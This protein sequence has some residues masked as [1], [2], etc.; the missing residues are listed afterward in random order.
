MAGEPPNPTPPATPPGGVVS[1]SCPGCGAPVQLRAAGHTVSVACGSCATLIDATDPN[2]QVL[3]RYHARRKRE[4]LIPL[5]SRG[6]LFGTKYEVIGFLIRSD[7]S[8]RYKWREYLLF[9]PYHGFRWLV[10]AAGHWNFVTMLRDKPTEGSHESRYDGKTFKLFLRGE[11]VVHYVLGEFY[12]RIAVGDR[13][14]V[15]DFICPPQMLSFEGDKNERIWSQAEYVEPEVVRTAFQVQAPFPAKR[16]VAPNQPAKFPSLTGIFVLLLALLIVIQGVT[17]ATARDETAWERA[18]LYLR[19]DT[20]NVVVTEPFELKGRVANVAVAVHAPVENNWI[21]FEESLVNADTGRSVAFEQGVSYYSGF[22]SD[23]AWTEGKH[24]H[25]RMLNSIPPGR[26]Q[27]RITPTTA[28]DNP[29]VL[30]T[31][32]VKRDVPNWSNFFTALGLLLI[33]PL[34][35]WFQRY[36]FEVARWSESDYSPYTHGGDDEE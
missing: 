22:D 25:V 19:G 36:N 35:S 20:N 12:W 6:E 8:G 18:Y 24:R 28:V 31:L 26:Y 15:A 5:G 32:T 30:Y 14:N 34:L 2:H 23:G 17:L 27:L 29:E 21:E 33:L 7:G 11:A 9:N 4:P 13:V 16:G 1:F 3:A 10:E